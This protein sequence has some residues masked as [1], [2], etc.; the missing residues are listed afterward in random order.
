TNGAARRFLSESGAHRAG[1]ACGPAA[2]TAGFMAFEAGGEAGCDL[3]SQGT[4]RW[5]PASNRAGEVCMDG[6]Q[7]DIC[8][9]I[10]MECVQIGYRWCGLVCGGR[11]ELSAFCRE[12]YAEFGKEK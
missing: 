11:Q 4:L 5:L 8:L 7:R 9:R 12:S 10:G 2:L 6:C 3:T 1:G